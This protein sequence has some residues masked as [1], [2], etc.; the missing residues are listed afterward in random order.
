[1]RTKTTARSPL[2]KRIQEAL[3]DLVT[4]DVAEKKFKVVK[5]FKKS[6]RRQ[7]LETNLTRDEAKRVVA[8][9]PSSF[10]SMVVF[11]EM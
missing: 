6:G 3:D 1:M 2:V 8:R 10:N 7:T 9:Y 5:L 11:Y 4:N